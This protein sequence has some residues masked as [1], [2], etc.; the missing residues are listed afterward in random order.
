MIIV[1]PL[2]NH[3]FNKCLGMVI[4]VGNIPYTFKEEDLKK[5]FSEFQS[6]VSAKL[7]VDRQTNRS[8]GYGFVELTD[9]EEA[10]VAVEKLNN[11]QVAGRNIKVNNAHKDE[12]RVKE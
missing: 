1:L 2:I 9:E 5:V 10:K 12:P 7:I 11:S 4:Y 3:L 8:K 6:V